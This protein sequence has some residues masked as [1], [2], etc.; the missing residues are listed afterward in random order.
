MEKGATP[1]NLLALPSDTLHKVSKAR[2]RVCSTE[3]RGPVSA[4]ETDAARERARER[5][6]KERQTREIYRRN[7]R[8]IDKD[9]GGSEEEGHVEAAEGRDRRSG[10][11]VGEIGT[12]EWE[13]D[14]ARG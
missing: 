2:R 9:I 10:D 14:S 6:K 5:R 13:R 8:R 7:Q 12:P 1:W 11:R 4:S 3:F